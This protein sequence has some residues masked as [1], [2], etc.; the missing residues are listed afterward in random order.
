MSTPRT[1]DD[2]SELT[3]AYALDA[4]EAD[5]SEVMELHLRDCPRCATE[6]TSFRET[7]ALLAHFGVEAPTGMWERLVNSL[8][9]APPPIAPVFSIGDA[10]PKRS[11]LRMGALAVAAALIVAIPAAALVI[12]QDNEIDR[13]EA[14]A[15]QQVNLERVALA[16]AADPLSRKV[17]LASADGTKTADAVILPDGRGYIIRHDLPGLDAAHTYQLWGRPAGA[18][19]PISL[20]VL[21]A[22]PKVVAFAATSPL[23]RMGISVEPAG[24]SPAPSGGTGVM[25]GDVP[26]LAAP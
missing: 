11:L 23:I 14:A 9:D 6:V 7:A 5:E 20:G 10:P 15:R 13:V 24:G 18:D 16:A 8:D 4:L 25:G 17:R 12:R 21:G 26:P 22:S 3:G 19:K 1:H 2:L